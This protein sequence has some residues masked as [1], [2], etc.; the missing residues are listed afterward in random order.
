MDSCDGLP[1]ERQN[2]ARRPK[3]IGGTEVPPIFN[4][5]QM[6]CD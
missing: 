1:T 6:C 3:A 2:A 5:A 4:A